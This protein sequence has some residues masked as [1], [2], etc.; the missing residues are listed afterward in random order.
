MMVHVDED[1]LKRLRD[2]E[3]LA[4]EWVEA[5]GRYHSQIAYA[6]L[7]EHFGKPAVW[8]EGVRK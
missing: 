4:R 8:P 1:E 3:R 5:K 6:R 7:L 2:T